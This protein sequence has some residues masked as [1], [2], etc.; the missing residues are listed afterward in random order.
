MTLDNNQQAFFALLRAGLWDQ[1]VRLSKFGVIDYMK[2]YR[3][4]EEQSVVGLVAAGLGNLADIR[5]P[6][7]D[8]L[9]FVGS[10]LQMERRNQAMNRFIGVLINKMTSAGIHSLLVKGQ[11]VAQCYEKPMWRMCGDVDLLLDASNYEQAK[12][13]LSAIATDIEKEDK[14]RKHIGLTIDSWIVELHGSMMPLILSKKT[15]GIIEG[16][17][18]QSFVTNTVRYW[19]NDGTNVSL[20]PVD[21]DV[22]FIFTH[23]LQHYYRGGIGLRQICDWCRLLWVY[24]DSLNHNLLESRIREMGL[25]SEWKVF[26]ALAIDYLGMPKDFVPL[27][28]ESEK[29]SNKASRVMSFILETGNFGH[30]RDMSYVGRKPYPIQKIISLFT[31]MNYST[32]RFLVFPKN[33]IIAFSRYVSQNSRAFF[34]GD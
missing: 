25:M 23:I 2:V 26:G 30:N 28:D 17:T 27:Y 29:W 20:P 21:V 24:Q 11:G 31:I 16:I 18:K 5:A 19:D 8:V 12:V 34:N 10:A 6:K 14:K 7:E 33:S 32:K 15:D 1:E 22:L 13:F 3:L 4:A 9:T